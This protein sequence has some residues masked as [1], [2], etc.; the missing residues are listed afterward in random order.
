MELK[1]WGVDT[2]NRSEIIFSHKQIYDLCGER[3]LR[4]G[5]VIEIKY[6]SANKSTNPKHYRVINATPSGNFRYVWLYMTCNIET[7][8]ADVAVKPVDDI[9]INDDQMEQGYRETI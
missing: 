1:K 5:D 4:A 6:N 3:M 7:L 9:G 2:I 8:T